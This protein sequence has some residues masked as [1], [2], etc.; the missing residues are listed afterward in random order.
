MGK[1]PTMTST[2][3]RWVV[4]L[5]EALG[6]H[7]WGYP[8]KMMAPAVAQLGAFGA[9]RWFAGNLPRYQRTL[10][11]LGEVRT[12]L[13]CLAISLINQCE[14][15]SVAYAYALQ[16]AYLHEHGHLFPL[17]ERQLAHLR[18]EPP[19]L[20]RHRLIE[21]AQ[22]A[23][24]HADIRWLD[25]TVT[26]LL[27]TD[28]RPTDPDDV[29]IAHLVEMFSQLNAIAITGGI[30]PDEAPTPLIKNGALKSRY[31][32]LRATAIT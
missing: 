8:P 23:G 3:R 32:H 5:L 11:S 26:L 19:A 27:G 18:G 9:L 2:R 10:T 22:H 12:H 28:R 24:L 6:E 4:G 21:A 15:C 25:R 17:D 31:A 29:R 20:I 7:R 30:G 16:L 14:Y 13:L 1:G